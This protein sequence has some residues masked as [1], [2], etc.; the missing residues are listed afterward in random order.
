MTYWY[1]TCAICGITLQTND[2]KKYYC[3]SCYKTYREEILSKEAWVQFCV[4]NEQA[5]RRWDTYKEK[6]EVKRV[7]FVWLGDEWDI[8]EGKLV[9]LKEHWEDND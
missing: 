4:A 9:P 8:S 1:S 7:E 5:R 3:N 2:P 6:G